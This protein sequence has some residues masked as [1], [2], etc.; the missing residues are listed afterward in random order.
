MHEFDEL[1]RNSNEFIDRLQAH[2]FRHFTP[3]AL[4]IKPETRKV[5]GPIQ[6]RLIGAEPSLGGLEFELASS[7][8][9]VLSIS[10]DQGDRVVISISNKSATSG[11]TRMVFTA[12]F[13]SLDREVMRAVR[14]VMADQYGESEK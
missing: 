9:L 7:R 1:T 13:S 3:N 10:H 4:R 14:V 2:L 8:R 5:I 11:S 12:L 6:S